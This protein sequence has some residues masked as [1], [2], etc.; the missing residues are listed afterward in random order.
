MA[1]KQQALG[2]QTKEHQ[3]DRKFG[4]VSELMNKRGLVKIY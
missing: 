3:G 2:D 1:A 4:V